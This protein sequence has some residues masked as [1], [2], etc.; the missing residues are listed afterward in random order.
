FN[1]A[2]INNLTIISFLYK[3]FVTIFNRAYIKF[4]S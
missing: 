3:Y 1:K 4:S 2:I